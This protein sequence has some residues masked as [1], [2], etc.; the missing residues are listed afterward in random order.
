M[1]TTDRHDRVLLDGQW[2]SNVAAHAQKAMDSCNR[3]E[4]IFRSTEV[5]F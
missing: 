2:F 4:T 3:I 1:T 5:G